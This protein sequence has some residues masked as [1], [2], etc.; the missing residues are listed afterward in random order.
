MIAQNAHQLAAVIVEPLVQGAAGIL[1]APP[2]YLKRVREIATQYDLLMIADEVAVGFGR[3]GTMFACEQEQV[4]PDILTVAKGITAG[5]LPLAATLTTDEVYMAFYGDY[6]ELK[7]FFHGHS[8]TGNPLAAAAAIANLEVF[9]RERVIEGLAAK[10]AV[11]KEE[12]ASFNHLPHVG[13]VRQ[14]G[15]MVGIELVSDKA[16]RIAYPWEQKIGIQ[17]CMKA[18][19]KGLIIRPLGHVI[20]FMPPLASST[21]EI[22][23]MLCIIKASIREVTEGLSRC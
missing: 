10:I 11:A 6:E 15:L 14:C 23:E 22:R 5:Y 12:L 21:E 2:G 8:Y 20:V 18:R 19:E 4:S 7:T 13:E 16:S 3:T 1:T 17:V 9:E